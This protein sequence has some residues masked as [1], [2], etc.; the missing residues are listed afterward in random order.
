MFSIKNTP[1]ELISVNNGS[2]FVDM[3]F[4]AN[5]II[6]NFKNILSEL[7]KIDP[8][9]IRLINNGRLLGDNETVPNRV[10]VIF[11]VQ[12][13]GG[14]TKGANNSK[15]IRKRSDVDSINSQANQKLK[16]QKQSTSRPSSRNEQPLSRT[17][18]PMTIN[19]V[20]LAGPATQSNSALKAQKRKDKK[21]REFNEIEYMAKNG[22]AEHGKVVKCH[23]HNNIPFVRLSSGHEVRC[24]NIRL[25]V[26]NIKLNDDVVVVYKDANS[27]YIAHIFNMENDREAELFGQ[28]AVDVS[29]ARP[30]RDFNGFCGPRPRSLVNETVEFVPQEINLDDIDESPDEIEELIPRFNKSPRCIVAFG[31]D[32]ESSDEEYESP[33]LSK[34]TDRKPFEFMEPSAKQVETKEVKESKTTE[35]CLWKSKT[36]EAGSARPSTPS[37][38]PTVFLLKTKVDYFAKTQGH[39]SIVDSQDKC[40]IDASALGEFTI[41]KNDEVI[42]QA[43][44]NERRNPRYKAVK[45]IEV[46]PSSE[47]FQG[48]FLYWN[49]QKNFGFMISDKFPGK[50]VFIPEFAV[51][52]QEL[53]NKMKTH[54]AQS[55]PINLS[56]T[57][58][59]EKK[60]QANYVSNPF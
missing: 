55:E 45:V 32:S 48:T 28:I 40:Y 22:H 7:N 1:R 6:K 33:D 53:L 4:P 5:L 46:K 23:E 56:F 18:S 60:L 50:K 34:F 51:K 24:S 43:V 19:D 35:M 38:Q 10:S 54:N 42:V 8:S 16:L 12:G 41:N 11:A 47:V 59:D 27:P 29:V 2:G 30:Q 3:M 58:F 20:P 36:T 37:A 25:N 15:K 14:N 49:F 31:S 17:S 52:N 26:R 21:E 39:L 13:G 44:E 9:L 57:M